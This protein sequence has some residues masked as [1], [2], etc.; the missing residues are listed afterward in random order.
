MYRTKAR[1]TLL[2][3]FVLGVLLGVYLHREKNLKPKSFKIFRDSYEEW[4]QRQNIKRTVLP[5]DLVRYGNYGTNYM[6]SQFLYDKVKLMCVLLVRKRKNAAAANQ[7]WAQHCNEKT[8]IYLQSE[9]VQKTK[10]PIR[11]TKLESSWHLLCDAIRGMNITFHWALFLNDDT[12]A[13]PENVRRMVAS[14]DYNEGHYLGHAITFWGTDYNVAQAGYILSRKSIELLRERFNSTA[15]CVAGGRF[16]KQEDYYL[17][18]HLASLGVHPKD[19]RDAH[20]LTTFH[21]HTLAQLLTPGSLPSLAFSNYYAR[22]LYPATECCS[23]YAVTFQSVEA[24]KMHT[25]HYLLYQLQVFH[26]GGTLGNMRSKHRPE[27]D[28]KVCEF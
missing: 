27:D 4:F 22:S 26:D 18:K 25:N 1:Y 15:E 9:K 24:D 6:E 20:G 16:W 13:L 11:Q 7:T 21:G 12:F 5:M 23:T 19:T 28:E 3:S 8:F 14:L 2:W 10:L 17:G